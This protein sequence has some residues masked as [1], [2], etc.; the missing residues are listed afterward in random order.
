MTLMIHNTLSG[1]K[2]EFVPLEEGKI[3][4][5]VCGPTVYDYSHIGHAR[6]Y[7]A[8]D[9]IRRYL[10]FKGYKITFVSNITDIDDKIIN[11]ANELGISPAMLAQKYMRAFFREMD[12]LKV[13]E[14]DVQPLATGHIPE[15]IEL[16]KRLEENGYAYQVDG[17]VYYDVDKFKDYGKLSHQNIDE[18]KAGA[19]VAPNEKKR[20]PLDF[21]LWK[22]SKPGEPKW[23]SP[24]GY[25]RPGWHIE[26]TA[27]IM[28]HLGEQI[29]IHGGG[30]DL[31][32]PHHENEIAQAEGATHKKFVKYWMH[33]GFLNIRG[34]KMSKSL[35][36]I[37]PI[38]KAL[39]LWEPEVLRLFFALTHYRRQID[40]SEE[41]V[42]NAKKS[43]ERLY[44]TLSI[45]D[46]SKK[47]IRED[48]NEE[49]KRFIEF[50]AQSEKDFLSNMDDDFNTP[51][52]LAIVFT[53][54][55]EVNKYLKDRSPNREALEKIEKFFNNVKEIFGILEETGMKEKQQGGLTVNSLLDLIVN[56][57]TIL[58]KNK[59]YQLADMIRDELSKLGVELRDSK[60]GTTY[61]IK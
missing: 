49:D 32:F 33:T 12:A 3:R 25:G 4:M 26:C 52:A 27:M 45:I 56:I 46:E 42:D 53:V 17:D 7:I 9:I 10:E 51:G 18:L 23:N 21:A 8:F 36:N 2:E 55:R 5:Y 50:I 14:P 59:Q 28:K 60:E 11:R 39:E 40:F 57:R 54:A 30:Q 35:G 1:K 44:N 41:G 47:N 58:R 24:W 15:I 20:N 29:D 16:I 38:K 6:T 37:I 19:R 61:V 31:I 34:E 13:K 22:A 43:L 48:K